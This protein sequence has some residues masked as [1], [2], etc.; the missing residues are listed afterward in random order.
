M[1]K[2]ILLSLLLPVIVTA[3]I[4][5]IPNANFKAY[6]VNNTSINTNLDSEI[7]VAEASAFTDSMDVSLWGIS[8]LTGIEAILVVTKK[9][10]L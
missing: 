4:V 10:V 3:Q 2:L 1:K 7:Q 8:D 6:L 5:N 9:M